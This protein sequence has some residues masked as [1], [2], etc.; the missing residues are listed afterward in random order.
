MYPWLRV[1]L[2]VSPYSLWNHAQLEGGSVAEGLMRTLAYGLVER[3]NDVVSWGTI[4][5]E[6]KYSCAQVLATV[7]FHE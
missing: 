6:D 1:S 2:L 7:I 3:C 4:F 5:P